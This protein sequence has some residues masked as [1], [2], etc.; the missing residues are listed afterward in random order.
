VVITVSDDGGLDADAIVARA[1]EHGIFGGTDVEAPEQAPSLIFTPGLSTAATVTE[2]S[3][4][5]VGMDVVKRNIEGLRGQIEIRSEEGKGSVFT[6]RLPLTLAVIDGMV[7][8]VGTER[9]VVPT[10]SIVTSLRPTDQ[11]LSTVIGRGE[12]VDVQ[13]ELLP[14]YRLHALFAVAGARETATEALAVVVEDDGKRACLLVDQLLGQQQI[15][16]KTL[17]ETL[18]GIPGISGGAIMPD[19]RVGLILDVGG[20][21][22]LAHIGEPV[23]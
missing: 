18:Q 10:L 21:V 19:G 20:L 15:V 5:G 13:G 14:L 23:A 8:G 22:R 1:R 12:M 7:V 11:V 3:G 2:I 16:I 4:R 6:L 17:G 9:Y